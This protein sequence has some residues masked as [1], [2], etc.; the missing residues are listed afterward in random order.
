VNYGVP[1]FSCWSK[2]ICNLEMDIMRIKGPPTTIAFFWRRTPWIGV[3]KPVG[4][5]PP[6]GMPL[7]SHLDAWKY[8]DHMDTSIMNGWVIGGRVHWKPSPMIVT[9]LS[10]I[11]ALGNITLEYLWDPG[12]CLSLNHPFIEPTPIVLQ[13]LGENQRCHTSLNATWQTFETAIMDMAHQLECH[14]KLNV[15]V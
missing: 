9:H 6:R 15:L 10:T 3:Q 14:I 7:G 4:N 2:S 13:S 11:L 8:S 1:S 12:K 5:Y